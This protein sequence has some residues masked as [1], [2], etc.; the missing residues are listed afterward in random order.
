MRRSLDWRDA[1]DYYDQAPRWTHSRI[2][3]GSV[4]RIRQPLRPE[5]LAAALEEELGREHLFDT[6][7]TARLRMSKLERAWWVTGALWNC[8]DALQVSTCEDVG[9]PRGSTYAEATP[10]LRAV[11]RQELKTLDSRSLDNGSRRGGPTR[12]M[13][14]AGE[15]D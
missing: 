13:P 10:Y 12:P 7:Y 8:S 9:L 14:A 11:I 6:N 15:I 5:S 2:Y 1:H 3:S 4:L